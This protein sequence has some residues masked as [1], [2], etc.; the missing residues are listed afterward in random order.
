MTA[1]MTDGLAN[2]GMSKAEISVPLKLRSTYSRES[3]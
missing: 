3:D 1:A 2:G